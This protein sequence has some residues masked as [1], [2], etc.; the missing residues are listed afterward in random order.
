MRRLVIR[1]G[2]I[3]DTILSFPAME[4]LRTGYLEIWVRSE[5]VPLIAFADRVRAIGSTG[6]DLVGLPGVEPPEALIEALGSFGEIV[7][8]YGTNRPEFRESLGSFC[9]FSSFLPALP[10]AGSTV[11]AADFFLRQVGG[12]GRAV[13]AIDA[14]AMER[15]ESTVFHPLS[16]SPKKNWPLPEF[17]KLE[18]EWPGVE[19]AAG[20]DWVRFENLM[21][22]GRWLA[23]ARL[24]VGND[25]GIT[26]LAAAVGV[27]VVALFGPTDPAVWGPRGA[28]VQVVR[29]RRMEDITIE[30][31]RQAMERALRG[32]AKP[33]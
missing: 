21:E 27:P 32:T 29:A 24:Y 20:P 16:G 31:V 1:P 23:G 12:E 13:P 28:Q 6:I 4:H 18:R 11:H 26:H 15:R 9:R 10:P 19:W 22:L 8:W 17:L 2:G 14:G 7:S 30:A 5:I 3:G 25:A 33:A